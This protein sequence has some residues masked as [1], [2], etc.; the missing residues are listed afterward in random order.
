MY[1]Y[2]GALPLRLQTGARRVVGDVST[3]DVSY[4]HG[5]GGR[6][7]ASVVTGSR[8]TGA[9]IVLAHGGSADGRHFLVDEAVQLARCGF[10]V[11]LPATAFPAHGDI[12]VTARAIS[13]AVLTQRRALDVLT[14][15]AGAAPDR[16]GFFGH[17]G[18]AFQGAI[19]SAVEPRLRALVLASYGSGTLRRLAAEELRGSSPTGIGSY[20]D[21]LDR[22]DGAHYVAVKGRRRLLFQHGRD[23][24]TVLRAEAVRLYETAAPPRQWSEYAC[25]HGTDADPDARKE[26][27]DFFSML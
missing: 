24:E 25:G 10:T 19:L 7:E 26:R 14:S 15:W 9:G 4:D 13:V 23:D 22:F 3:T 17:S 12:D 18:G 11:V 27:A 5:A 16:L 2:D 21:A 1:D 20:L 8:A 6:A